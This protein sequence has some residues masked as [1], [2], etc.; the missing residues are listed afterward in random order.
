M[1][2]V[3]IIDIESEAAKIKNQSFLVL[4]RYMCIFAQTLVKP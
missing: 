4:T 3:L 2:R 1:L